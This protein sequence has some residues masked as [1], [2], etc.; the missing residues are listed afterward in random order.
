MLRRIIFH[1]LLALFVANAANRFFIPDLDFEKEHQF[2]EAIFEFSG[3]APDQYR[4]LPLLGIKFVRNGLQ[5][6]KPDTP[7]NHAILVF[8]FFCAFLIFELFYFLAASWSVSKRIYFNLLFSILYI[9]TQYTGW[10]PDTLG[11]LLIATTFMAALV[12]YPDR[13]GV[14]TAGL[15]VLSFA[16]SDIALIYA[17]FI[18][19]TFQKSLKFKWLLLLIPVLIQCYLQFYLFASATYYTK[20]LMLLDNLSGYY[21]AYNP[22]TW[23]I[24]AGGV[25]FWSDLRAYLGR[26]YQAIPVLLWLF[27]AYLALVLVV[28]R[29]N[30][31]R[32]Y[33]PFVPLWIWA[34]QRINKISIHKE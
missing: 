27:L 7:I 1:I 21:L 32:L 33:L 14:A 15:I 31:Y 22:A 24:I 28:G 9:Y 29:I 12:R 8:N 20:P 16:R 4:I 23:L 25:I 34:D 19:F 18:C 6:I 17:V 13:W 30:E 2:Y 5:L 26:M 3:Q 11:L 10:R